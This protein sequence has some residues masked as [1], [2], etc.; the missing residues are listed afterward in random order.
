MIRLPLVETLIFP[1]IDWGIVVYLEL[2][3]IHRGFLKKSAPLKKKG[4]VKMEKSFL[5]LFT[6]PSIILNR[7]TTFH[8]INEKVVVEAP[9]KLIRQLIE[10][11]DGT[12][13][14]NDVVQ[15]LKDEWDEHSIRSLVEELRRRKV[16]V[17]SRYISDTAWKAIENPSHFQSILTDNDVALLVEQARNRQR[18]GLPD[19]TYQVSTSSFG[20]ILER[21]Q[22]VRCFSGESVEF[23]NIIRMLWSGYGEISFSENIDIE[24]NCRKTVPSAGAMYPLMI[25]MALFK[26]TEELHPGI[27]NVWMGAPKT[28]GFNLVS[29]D[30]DRF[31]RS[32]ADPMVLEKT[33]GVIVV[34]GS[35]HATGEKYG[36]RSIL[37]V[38]LEAGH[39]A[40][41]I[42]IAASES[43]VATVEI[44]G[45]IEELLAEAIELKN[46]Y[47]PLTA[48]VFGQEEKI[49]Q[50]NISKQ[51]TNIEVDWAIPMAGQYRLPFTTAFARVSSIIDKDWSCG[52]AVSPKLAQIKATAEARE[53][54]ACGSISDLLVQ[55]KFADLETA[56]DPRHIIKFHPAQYRLKGFPF[57]PF[58]KEIEYAWVE[59][60]DELLGSKVHILADCVYYPFSPQAPRYAHASSSGVAA[61]PEKQQAIKNGVLELVERDAFMI[62]YLAQIFS[63]TVSE[64][65]L[66]N[67]IQGRINNLR[68]IGFDVWIKDY[69]IDLAPVVFIFIQNEDIAFTTCAGCSNF[70]IEEALDHALMEI[71][72][73]VLCRLANG[74]SKPI[75]LSK[76]HLPCDHGRLYEQRRF[77]RKADFLKYS[78]NLVA[79]QEV[80]QRVAQSWQE[81][82]NRF[83]AKG[84]SLVTVT[85]NLADEFGG[86]SGLHIVR[87]IV[88]GMVPISFGYREVPCAM[89][90]VYRVAKEIGGLSISYRNMPTFP[91]P[92]T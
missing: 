74:A 40:Q 29:R 4:S 41:N 15:V 70:N 31:V 38:T 19:K 11:C 7:K 80:G 34:S 3:E 60:K 30:I 83:V 77:F 67:G 37:Y 46:N 59:G 18:S 8:K 24:T 57:K 17:D 43:K 55:A 20:Q 6:A 73:S 56:I 53:W 84:W 1:C 28:V 5:P 79:F 61:H 81:L 16:L 54:A 89:E 33:H 78:Q 62:F 25:S 35:F 63:P 58:S 32:F 91:H 22:S 71:E 39:V 42:L 26:D 44:G 66:P 92:Y 69:S 2:E 27:Y 45:F 85:L 87:S 49:T 47:R 64:K 12:R 13:V 21:R 86:N 51:E 36:N 23:Q 82:L 76:V 48:I 10:I 52:R 75:E 88:P 90:R 14:F 50:V 9:S 68:K 72:S 65:T